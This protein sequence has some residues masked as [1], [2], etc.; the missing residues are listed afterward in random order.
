[1]SRQREKPVADLGPRQAKLEHSRLEKEIAEH[2][3][4]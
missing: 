2:D 4:R 1:M 3:K